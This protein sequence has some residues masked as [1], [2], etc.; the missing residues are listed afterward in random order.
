MGESDL[1]QAVLGGLDLAPPDSTVTALRRL[2]AQ[3]LQA[4][5]VRLLLSNYQLTALRPVQDS[6]DRELLR[7]TPAGRVFVDQ[8]P[9]TRPHPRRGVTVFLPLTVRGDRLGVLQLTVA[10]TPDRAG[11]DRLT[12]LA[13]AIAHAVRAAGRDT[14]TLERAAR[15][16]RLSLAAELQWQLLPG[17]GCRA[18]E[19]D[20]AGHLEPAYHVH[21]DNF[22]WSQNEN[23]LLLSIADAARRG[24]V[25]ALLT[26]LAVT[27]LRNAR[28]S[29]ASP[30]DQASLADQAVYAHHQGHHYISTLL[31]EIDLGTG[32]ARAVSAGTPR[33]FV[34]RGPEVLEP[35]LGEQ[36]PLGMFDRTDYAEDV[37][38][39]A[40]GDRLL[41]V[42]DGVHAARSPAR[43]AFGGLA[44][45][46]L[47][48]STATAPPGGVVRAVIDDLFAHR[49]L[50]ELDDDAAVLCLDWAGPSGDAGQATVALEPVVGSASHPTAPRLTVVPTTTHRNPGTN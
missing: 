20:L 10:D 8:R 6:D 46:N 39:L 35:V 25:A 31:V 15:S 41:M 2:L 42:S 14:D 7:D 47:L 23:R 9:L 3:H 50:A 4:T 13:G 27:A 28:R 16:Q 43:D 5:D 24:G 32:L 33:L 48:R 44:L 37:F 45:P 30:A 22:D 11:L 40:N 19:Y 38:A 29:G 1:T 26:T 21:A 49:D 34:L 17:R 18:P 12:G 36:M